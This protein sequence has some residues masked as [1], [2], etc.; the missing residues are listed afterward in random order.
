MLTTSQWFQ[1]NLFCFWCASEI[2]SHSAELEIVPEPVRHTVCMR[3]KWPIR[4][5]LTVYAISLAWNDQCGS[6]N[7]PISPGWDA[8][9]S[10]GYPQHLICWYP[11]I[12]LDEERHCESSVLP[13][14][15]TQCPWLGLKPRPLNLEVSKLTMRPPCLHKKHSRA[16]INILLNSSSWYVL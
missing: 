14:N 15:A 16:I 12:Y 10:Q 8:S 2:W 3:V 5:A 7:F 11:F 6:I 13:K 1:I 9:P 4:S